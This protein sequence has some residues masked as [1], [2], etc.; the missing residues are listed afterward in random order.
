MEGTVG[1]ALADLERSGLARTIRDSFALTATLS[2]V[3]AVGFTLIMGGAL[4]SNLRLAG[5]L[6][7]ERPAGEVVLPG[8]R[9]IQA[10]LAISIVTGLLLFAPRAVAAAGSG[11]FRLKMLALITAVAVQFL[12]IRP[13][14]RRGVRAGAARYL[15]I[16]GLAFWT[17]LA[18]AACAYIL[19]E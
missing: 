5:A 6:F 8:V 13:A 16:V 9:S 14:V 7:R 4:L 15:G 10:G 19:L 1:T 18:L 17:S 12:V 11:M 2:A 3:H